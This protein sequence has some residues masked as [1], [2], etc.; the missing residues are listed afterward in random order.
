MGHRPSKR[1]FLTVV[2]TVQGSGS[3]ALRAAESVVGQSFDDFQLLMADCAAGAEASSL[4]DRIVDRDIRADVLHLDSPDVSTGR[5]AALAAARGSYLLFMNQ[6]D[7][8]GIGLLESMA[9][10]AREVEADLV[11]PPVSR[12]RMGR[13]G[14]CTSEV[15]QPAQCAWESAEAFHAGAAPFIQ[16]D[17]FTRVTGVLLRRDLVLDQGLSFVRAGD[18]ASFMTAYARGVQRAATAA[19]PCYHTCARSSGAAAPFDP[20]MYPRCEREHRTLMALC[21]QWG[22]LDNSDLMLAVHRRHLQ[23]VI[24]CIDNACVSGGRVSSI[25]RR[26]RVQDI[27]DAADTRAAI[28]ALRS[29]SHEFG[30]MYAPIARRSAAACFMRARLQVFAHRVLTPFLPVAAAAR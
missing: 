28:A 13:D 18:D 15:R 25:E 24:D 5:D 8:L 27:V 29:A 7:W 11:M 9:S 1:P 17:A 10:R 30:L 16:G 20:D 23:R 2:L 6:D 19:G 21:R 12:D 3:R 4:C 22:V 26:Q 14:A